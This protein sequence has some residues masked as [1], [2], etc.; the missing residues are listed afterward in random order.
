[1]AIIITKA[2]LAEQVKR[3][4]QHGDP[5]VGSRIHNAELKAAISNVI[6]QM[7]KT[8]YFQT[9]L[10]SGE[11]IPEGCV[12]ATY[13]NVPVVTYKDV[14]RSTLPAMPVKL[15]RNMGVYHIGKTDDTLSGFIPI[16]PGQYLFIE[17]QRL[18]SDIVDQVGYEVNGTTVIYTQ[19]LTAASPAITE[20][21]MKLVIMDIGLY[22]DYQM[23]PISAEMQW[24]VIQEV[25]KMFSAEPV[26][27]DRI[28]DSGAENK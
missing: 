9:T 5:S 17:P 3:L 8:D 23:L 15:F 26:P 10:P 13:D 6:N 18:L 11:T 20:V 7:L 28:D 1:M 21:L 4:L 12:L 2:Y 22:T 16:Q 25:F 24:Q 19:D 14:S 27:A